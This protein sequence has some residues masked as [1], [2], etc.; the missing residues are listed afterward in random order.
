MLSSMNNIFP[1]LHS[2]VYPI[3]PPQS[4]PTKYYFSTFPIL[5]CTQNT[6]SSS[7]PSTLASTTPASTIY[8]L[9]SPSSPPSTS[10]HPLP[11][12]HL[13]LNIGILLFLSTLT[14]RQPM[15]FL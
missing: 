4:Q 10:Q 2:L 5:P 15:S 12:H 13:P 3:F 11:P 6:A 14:P 8:L 7:V 1:H 9:T